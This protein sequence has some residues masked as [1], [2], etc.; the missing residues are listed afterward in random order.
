MHTLNLLLED[1]S[2]FF[3]G[4]G[5]ALTFGLFIFDDFFKFSDFRLQIFPLFAVIG[6]QYADLYLKR[7]TL[8]S[9]HIFVA[10]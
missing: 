3:G 9:E 10:S 2:L 8:L 4:L 5:N 6:A 1:L 7:C